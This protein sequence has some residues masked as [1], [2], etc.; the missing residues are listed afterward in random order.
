[1]CRRNASIRVNARFTKSLQMGSKQAAI[2]D[3]AVT[4]GARVATRLKINK[5]SRKSARPD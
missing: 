4:R 5:A 1:M 3:A 2:F